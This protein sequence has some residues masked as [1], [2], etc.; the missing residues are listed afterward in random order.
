MAFIDTVKGWFK[1]GDKP[2]QAQFYSMF[3]Y[4]RWKDEDIPITSIENIEEILNEKADAEIVSN[5]FVDAN[6][7][8]ALFLQ[9][10]IYV[11]SELQIFKAPG[12]TSNEILESGDW[13]IGFVQGQFINAN[14]LSGETTLLASFD[15]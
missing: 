2:T 11:A 6:A 10:K 13:C 7:H 5:H 8:T 9:T 3:A 1:T 14:Y 4:L 15:I 12:N